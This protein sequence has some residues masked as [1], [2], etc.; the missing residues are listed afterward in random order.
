MYRFFVAMTRYYRAIEKGYQYSDASDVTAQPNAPGGLRAAFG[1]FE[2]MEAT[3]VLL[4]TL[5]IG[6]KY[7][8]GETPCKGL[9]SILALS[10]VVA[11]TAPAFAGGGAPPTTKQD[12]EKAKMN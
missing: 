2:L 5:R 4:W 12:C 11:F 6:A 7:R 8:K 10:F 3:G 1:Q 9:V